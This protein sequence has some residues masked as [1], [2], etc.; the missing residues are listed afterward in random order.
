MKAEDSFR[1]L[2]YSELV[3][4]AGD[5][6]VSR[7]KSYQRNGMVRELYR[8]D[9]GR[10]LATVDGSF[11]YHTQIAINNGRLISRCT[12][13]YEIACKHAVAVA[14]EYISCLK[15]GRLVPLLPADDPLV[16]WLDDPDIGKEKDEAIIPAINFVDDL[17]IQLNKKTKSELI[18]CLT[19]LVEKHPQILEDIQLE[20]K[21]A[22]DSLARRVKSIRREIEKVSR[23]P[24]WWDPWHN[25]GQLPDYSRIQ[26]GLTQ[27]LDSGFADEVVKLG[28]LLFKRGLEQVA[29]SNDDGRTAQEISDCL[30]IVFRALVQ[31]SLPYADKLEKA[32]NYELDDQYDLWPGLASFREQSYPESAWS[33]LAD[34]LLI[35]L[36]GLGIH[37]AEDN[38]HERYFRNSLIDALF[39]A[40]TSAGR[41]SEVIPLFI[42]EVENTLDYPQLVRLL[43]ES[44]RLAEAETWIQK[45]YTAT[46]TKYPGISHELLDYFI[47]IKKR[48]RAWGELAAVRANMFFNSPDIST[49]HDLESAARKA[50][51]E[52]ELRTAV[53]RF[54]EKGAL[55]DESHKTW[56]LPDIDFLKLSKRA[57]TPRPNSELL[58]EIAIHERN[59]AE[60]L[61]WL[62]R[63]HN[64]NQ[65]FHSY[66]PE[67]LYDKAAEFLADEYPDVAVSVWKDL[68]E[69]HIRETKPKAY[70]AA[71]V[72]L[73]KILKRYEKSGRITEWKALIA[74]IRAEHIRKRRLMEILDGLDSK[75]IIDHF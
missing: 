36:K 59:S 58:L 63:I 13:P 12:C 54:L 71:V 26:K 69:S 57:S 44:N 18:R 70:Y 21:V 50:G 49:F 15:S 56:P 74:S 52:K 64:D 17:K 51:C 65:R 14:L 48:Q 68:A 73:K 33:E 6:I 61:R 41:E 4:W 29:G 5:K 22:E 37:P 55:P 43:I 40:L 72:Y 2:T 62:E 45:G 8:T 20:E 39:E 34:R 47:K 53:F 10:L 30:E 66:Y 3:E 35:R 9:D 25:S 38:F 42:A 7:G 67:S 28:D 31:C 16:E 19:Q 24:A 32:I 75:P 60:V 1:R 27:L 11:P 46:L 23:E